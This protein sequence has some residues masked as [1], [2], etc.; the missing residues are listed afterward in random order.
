[1][2]FRVDRKK[3][4]PR[5]REMLEET[6]SEGA[7]E[8][9]ARLRYMRQEQLLSGGMLRCDSCGSEGERLDFVEVWSGSELLYAMCLGC[10]KSDALG[11]TVYSDPG[12]V[13]VQ[14]VNVEGQTTVMTGGREFGIRLPS[15]YKPDRLGWKKKF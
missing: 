9:D 3:L 8:S 10:L 1:M 5:E 2:G 15:K 12:G 11:C 7:G 13:K 6:L 4:L 14:S